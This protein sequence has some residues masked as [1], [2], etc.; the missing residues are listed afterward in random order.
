MRSVTRYEIEAI[1]GGPRTLSMVLT[2]LRDV[3][4]VVDRDDAIV[5]RSWEQVGESVRVRFEFAGDITS[6]Y[7]GVAAVHDRF[8]GFGVRIWGMGDAPSGRDAESD[9][10]PD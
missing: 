7:A 2:V 4:A 5:G 8:P 6:V 9:V 10:A 1:P 3:G